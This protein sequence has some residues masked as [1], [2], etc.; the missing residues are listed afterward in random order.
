VIVTVP[1]LVPTTVG[2]NVTFMEQLADVG[3]LV[4]QVVFSANG[5]VIAM[6]VIVRDAVPVLLSVTVC[7]GLVTPG[8]SEG[9]VKL[10]GES[11]TA[12]AAV[13]P[14]A[15]VA[16]WGLLAA[17]SVTINDPDRAPGAVGVNVM[18]IGQLAFA[19]REAPHGLEAMAKSPTVVILEMFK[20][21]PPELLRVTVCGALV[22]PTG[23][24]P[25]VRLVGLSEALGSRMPLPDKGKLWGEFEALSTMLTDA[26]RPPAAVGVKVTANAQPAPAARV[27]GQVFCET[28]KSELFSPATVM[29]AIVS[30]A[31]PEFVS[32]TD[33]A[34]LV[35][36]TGWSAKVRLVG[37]RATF[38]AAAP[39]PAR[40]TVCG[41]FAALSVRVK[42]P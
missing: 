7:A 27:A 25:N 1:V 9:N 3:K 15:R 11:V 28:A 39:V 16:D 40:G 26:R 34:L 29:L 31:P 22:V 37:A 18:L 20:A 2:V 10:V 41:L 32:I 38:G 42:V 19:A 24:E 33:W 30:E 5:P 35:V 4:P 17:L 23:S 36:F 14:P 8:D 6:L 21:A 12:G 13:A